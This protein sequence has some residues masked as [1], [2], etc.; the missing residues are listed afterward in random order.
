[1]RLFVPACG[2]RLTLTEPWTFRLF[3]E[4]R[5]I[6]FA[7]TRKFYEGDTTWRG[8]F[9]NAT[10]SYRQI[11]VTLPAGTILECDRVYIRTFNKSRVQEGDDYDSITWKVIDAKKGKPEMHGRFWTKLS[12][13]NEIEFELVEDSRYRDR[14]KL[15]KEVMQS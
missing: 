8:V 10:R 12:D 2:D 7:T 1:M 3:L 14:V 15:F 5:N 11:E 6:K 4:Q 9:D 13:A